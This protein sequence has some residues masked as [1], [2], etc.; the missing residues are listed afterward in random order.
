[1]S[2]NRQLV[3]AFAPVKKELEA[4]ESNIG[5]LAAECSTL[6]GRLTAARSNTKRLL[7]RT[8]TLRHHQSVAARVA[9]AR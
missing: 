3:E 2:T 8:R 5:Q 6:A 1:V 7:A 9:A 4:L